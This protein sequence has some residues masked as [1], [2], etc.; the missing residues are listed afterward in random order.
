MNRLNSL[1]GK[2]WVDYRFWYCGQEMFNCLCSVAA[3]P[4]LP[5]QDFACIRCGRNN[6]AEI[7][8]ESGA[9]NGG[10]MELPRGK[11]PRQSRA[12]SDK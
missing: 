10:A 4:R 5:Q 6:A 2:N 3:V 11:K 1:P 9:S 8:T 7:K 12:E